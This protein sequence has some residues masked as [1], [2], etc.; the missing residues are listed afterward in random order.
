MESS[1]AE[2][3]EVPLRTGSSSCSATALDEEAEQQ[4]KERTPSRVAPPTAARAGGDGHKEEL[5]VTGLLT[6]AAE[7]VQ[8]AESA[9]HLGLAV[10]GI[11]IESG[12]NVEQLDTTLVLLLIRY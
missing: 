10:S 5:E 6:E 12:R 8:D 11:G 1:P 9:A 7:G 3:A 2:T 4:H